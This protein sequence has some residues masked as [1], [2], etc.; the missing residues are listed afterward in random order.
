MA[1]ISHKYQLIYALAPRTASTATAN[2]LIKKLAFE[3]IPSEDLLDEVK[4]IKVAKKHCT[5]ADLIN[6]QILQKHIVK[7]YLTFVTVRN[8]FESLYSAWYKKK[9]TYT[10]L[11]E[12]KNSFIYKKPGFLEDMI[13]IRD[14]SFSDWVVK[15]YEK[16]AQDNVKRHLDGTYLNYADRVL[17]FEYLNE[18]FKKMIQDYNLPYPGEIPVINKTEGKPSNYR[19]FYTTEAREIITKTYSLD[20]E[21]FSY[22]F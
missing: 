14:N 3:W 2:Y 12:D 10:E 22:H 4:N 20:L 21:K 7:K 5:F 17:R 15:T 19:E 16:L 6:Y 9:Y 18:D 13:Y 1:V 8:P 11:L